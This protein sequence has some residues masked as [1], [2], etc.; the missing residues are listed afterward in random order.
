VGHILL[1]DED[2]SEAASDFIKAL[3]TVMQDSPE[4]RSLSASLQFALSG[5]PA[6]APDAQV[7]LD[8]VVA[9][10]TP[11]LLLPFSDSVLPEVNN[12]GT[13]AASAVLKQELGGFVKNPTKMAHLGRS[14]RLEVAELLAPGT[15]ASQPLLGP[16]HTR[17]LEL[18][19]MLQSSVPLRMRAIHNR[20]Q[21]HRLL[22]K[23]LRSANG[24]L[25]LAAATWLRTVLAPSEPLLAMELF[26]A[27]MHAGL[28]AALLVHGGDNGMVAVSLSALLVDSSPSHSLRG[29]CSRTWLA[30]TGRWRSSARG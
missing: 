3:L 18:L 17:I 20:Y 16:R 7:F 22:C 8:I 19:T 11:L 13:S 21:S 23:G 27:G 10:Y 24:L 9:S 5:G 30:V 28:A 12:L 4:D 25:C 14:R 2:K 1:S 26:E 15:R 6:A 29:R